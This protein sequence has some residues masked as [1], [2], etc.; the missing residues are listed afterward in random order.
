MNQSRNFRIGSKLTNRTHDGKE[1]SNPQ[2]TVN[3]RKKKTAR[4]NFED[5]ESSYMDPATTN[6]ALPQL[7]KSKTIDY[8]D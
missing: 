1:N 4:F 3:K 8:D 6:F 7:L 5:E 2:S